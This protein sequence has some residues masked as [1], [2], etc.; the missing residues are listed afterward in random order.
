MNIDDTVRWL[1]P[2]GQY[3]GWR[4]ISPPGRVWGFDNFGQF[5]RFGVTKVGSRSWF[6]V[7][8]DGNTYDDMRDLFAHFRLR[9]CECNRATDQLELMRSALRLIDMEIY[10]TDLVDFMVR[11]FGGNR[12]F[13]EH[14]LHFLECEKLVTCTTSILEDIA[15]SEEGHATLRMLDMTAAGSNVDATPAGALKRFDRLY[16]GKR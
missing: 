8:P 5:D 7:A 2:Y 1:G 12:A 15:L 3:G 10:R 4:Y 9:L 11:G 14:Y 6:F 13:G 16:P